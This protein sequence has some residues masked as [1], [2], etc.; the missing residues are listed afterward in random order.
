[1]LDLLLA[2]MGIPL[3]QARSAYKRD[4][5]PRLRDQLPQRLAA[6]GPEF[7]LTD[8]MFKSFQL[9]D[10]H[11]RCV[12]AVDAVHA[13]TA[14]LECSG[15]DGGEAAGSSSSDADHVDRFWNCYYALSPGD[16]RGNLRRG[17]DL[18]KKLQ[19]ALVSDGGR[20][21]S[22]R[23]YHNFKAFRM[24]DMADHR[25]SNHHLLCHPMA[26]QRLAAFFQDEMYSRTGRR[27][28]VVVIA[29]RNPDTGRCL[30][31]GYGTSQRLR[32]N[33]L[34][35][36]F[37]AA[38]EKVGARAWHDL[39]DTCVVEVTSSDVERFKSELLRMA[40]SQSLLA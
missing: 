23:L 2:K 28:P 34:G 3:Q 32:G 24:Y 26:L 14:L 11:D 27:R 38:S 25:M 9:Q 1:M 8:A 17:L 6:H 20:V 29:P 18:A 21:L 37:S 5:R 30:V 15:R 36:A 13:A 10:G 4:L 39:F 16:D 12:T 22:Q 40:G 19:Q 7:K 31:V 35:A 33:K